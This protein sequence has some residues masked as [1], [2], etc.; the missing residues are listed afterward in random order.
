MTAQQLA[1][2]LRAKKIGKDRWMA[3]CPAHADQHPSLSISPG[4]RGVLIRCRSN[5]CD[6]H[7]IVDAMGLKFR[8]LFY[9]S[10]TP[11]TRAHLSLQEVR[12]H[13]QEKFE[14]ARM[15]GLRGVEEKS[16]EQLQLVRCRLEPLEVY[17]EWRGRVWNLM[18]ARSREAY[19]EEVWSQLQNS[20]QHSVK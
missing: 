5:G 11:A 18:N 19:L 16:W 3:L 12:V 7:D 6:P 14:S 8:D 20:K 4:R 15:V 1:T 2:E 13:L 17:R 10:L 9:T